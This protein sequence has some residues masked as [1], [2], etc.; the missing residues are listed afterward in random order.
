VNR[1]EWK[2]RWEGILLKG[3]QL[4]WALLVIGVGILLLL[5]PSGQSA[6][7]T[8]EE[9]PVSSQTTYDVSQLEEKL[10]QVLG[11]I[12]GVGQVRVVLTLRSGTRQVYATERSESTD[13]D[14]SGE[15]QETVARV[16]KGSNQQEALEVMEV[17]PTFQG[18][19]VVCDG[20]QD[21]GVRLAVVES[22]AALTGL[23][24][25]KISVCGRES[26]ETDQG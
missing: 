26:G 23:S 21:P 3:K 6:E 2:K 17:Y 4:R 22:V 18:A 11:E 7:E 5:L 16:S 12:K 8:T 10:C 15:S 13:S 14:G 9:T 19:L 1:E 20:G 24:T 25:D